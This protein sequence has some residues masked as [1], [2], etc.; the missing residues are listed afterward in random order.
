MCK[1]HEILHPL[2]GGVLRGEMSKDEF[3]KKAEEVLDELGIG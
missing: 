1:A 2:Y 3:D